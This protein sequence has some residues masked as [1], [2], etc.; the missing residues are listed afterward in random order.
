MRKFKLQVQTTID[1]HMAVPEGEPG[2]PSVP[3]TEDVY[4]YMYALMESVDTIVL[5]RKIADEF[6]TAWASEIEDEPQAL[7]DWIN[8]AHKVVISRS[9]TDS[10]WDKVDVLRGNIVESVN[11][12]K[13]QPG[14][15]LIAYGGV[16]LVSSLVANDLLDDLYLFVNPVAIGDGRPVFGDLDGHRRFRL[17]DARAF[18]CGVVALHYQPNGS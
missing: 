7:I 12:L 10:Q 4:A 3:F 5:G 13:A 11:K 18:D 1:G 9:L 8:N 2:W 6:I 15:D 14:G 16:E 17:V